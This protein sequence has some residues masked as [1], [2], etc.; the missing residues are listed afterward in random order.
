L[1]VGCCA[2]EIDEVS[3]VPSAKS[4]AVGDALPCLWKRLRKYVG[5]TK[6]KNGRRIHVNDSKLVYSTAPNGLKELERAVLALVCT[7]SGA[8]DDRRTL[9]GKV[10][11]HVLEHLSEYAWYAAQDEERFPIEVDGMGNRSSSWAAYH[12]YSLRCSSTCGETLPS[13]VLRSSHAPLH[14]HT[15]A[16][17]ARSSSFNPFGAVE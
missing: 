5:K 4:Q 2:F 3:E 17:T 12:A 15:S 16:R 8:C 11:P 13:S 10:S 1:V 14:V 7:W 6:S 9:L